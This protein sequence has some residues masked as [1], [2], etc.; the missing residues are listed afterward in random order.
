MGEQHATGV[1]SYSGS[2]D[3]VSGDH[4]GGVSECPA[5]R[6]DCDDGT[7]GVP[8]FADLPLRLGLYEEALKEHPEGAP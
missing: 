8:E 7:V 3:F 1:G 5:P 4:R 6:A 2:H